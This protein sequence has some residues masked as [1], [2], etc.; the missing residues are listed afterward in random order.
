MRQV[1][2]LTDGD[3]NRQYHDHDDLIAEFARE[4]IPVSTIRIGP[5]LANLRLLQDF[6]SATGGVFYRVQDIE[7]LPQLLVGL[8]REAMNRRK[9]RPHHVEPGEP[10]AMLSG[11]GIKP[12]F[13]RS[14]FSPRPSAKDGAASPAQGRNAPTNR[15][16]ARRPGSTASAAP[17]FSPPIPIRWRR[18]AGFDGT[19]TRNSGRNW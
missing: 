9:S 19:A 18:S 8:T 10:S 16:A 5:D 11:I 4:H 12:R 14:I 1:I 7:K 3:T 17:R 6:A 13:R 15:A 2:L